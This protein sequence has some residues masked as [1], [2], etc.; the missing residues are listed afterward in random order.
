MKRYSD[1]VQGTMELLVD[2]TTFSRKEIKEA[3]YTPDPHHGGVWKVEA[4]GWTVITYNQ[5]GDFESIV[6]R[7]GCDE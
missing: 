2:Q 5:D 7:G 3:R 4:K 1:S 6:K